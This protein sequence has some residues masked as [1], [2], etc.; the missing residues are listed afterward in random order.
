MQLAEDHHIVCFGFRYAKYLDLTLRELVLFYI[1]SFCTVNE[2]I[3][4]TK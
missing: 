4:D 1:L 2:N 3:G